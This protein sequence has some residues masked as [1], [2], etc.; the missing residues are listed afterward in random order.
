MQTEKLKELPG[1]AVVEE[2][3]RR[4]IWEVD[5]V[6][7]INMNLIRTKARE[8]LTLITSLI[9]FGLNGSLRR[10]KRDQGQHE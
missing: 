5:L 10:N 1:D 2:M 7:L 4:R 9:G 6:D 8:T 3:E